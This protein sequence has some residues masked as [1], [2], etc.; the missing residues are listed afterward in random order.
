MEKINLLE[1]LKDC[2]SGM[3]LYSPMFDNL[4][5]DYVNEDKEYPIGYPIRCY[6][7]NDSYR[8]STAFNMY[9]EYTFNQN[10]KC[11][12]FPKGKST[13]EGFIPPCKFKDGDIV[14][15]G[16]FLIS[17][18][19]R[20]KPGIFGSLHSYVSLNGGSL[21]FD[22]DNWTLDNI[23]F[24]TEEEKTKLFKAIKD[25]G[26]KWNEETKTFEKLVEP[27]FK[28]GDRIK[29][30]NSGICDKVIK[31]FEDCYL[32]ESCFDG[33]ATISFDIQDNWELVP[34]KFDITTLKPFDKV[35]IRQGYGTVWIPSFWGGYI[36]KIN[37]SY[38]YLTSYGCVNQCI[39][40]EGNQ[41]LL[42]TTKNP[43]EYGNE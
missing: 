35:L 11:V 1:I 18:F 8:T 39:P 4:Y 30:K 13:W 34:N 16:K 27:K 6:I 38:P 23:R 36:P 22:K 43:K 37:Q 31:I 12:I 41:E 15:C 33:Q 24:A 40:F 20:I 14:T 26:Y 17:I 2:P 29:N 10:S 21:Y 28:V 7:Q 9:G 32:V 3:E 5:F 42:G 19:K 25:N